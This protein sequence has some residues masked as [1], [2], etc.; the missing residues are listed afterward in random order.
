MA[1]VVGPALSLDASKS[2]KKTVTFQRRSSGN[3]IYPFQKPGG[4]APFVPSA[5]QN[6]Q[7]AL[8][9][10][11]VAQW[12]ALSQSAK[13]VWETAAKRARYIGTGYHYFIHTQAVVPE[14]FEWSG[15]N[16]K[17]SDPAVGWSG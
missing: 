11:L 17:W 4:R 3:V 1:K 9:G 13:D 8:I 6:T 14:V 5:G 12:Q 2:L 16:V 15:S 7:R 10:S